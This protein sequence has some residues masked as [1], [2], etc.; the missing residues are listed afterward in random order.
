MQYP[1]PGP[2]AAGAVGVPLYAPTP[3]L[4]PAHPTPFY[5]ATAH[6]L[7]GR[8]D[9]QKPARL[10]WDV[11]TW[12]QGCCSMGSRP[13]SDRAGVAREVTEAESVS[14]RMGVKPVG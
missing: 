2:A 8:T 14:S 13:R 11:G 5:I 12:V 9:A 3:L 1:H 4:Q 7:P 6:S 10:T